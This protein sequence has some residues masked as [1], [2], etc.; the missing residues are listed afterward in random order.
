MPS[1]INSSHLTD[2]ACAELRPWLPE[3]ADGQPLP[4]EAAHLAAHLPACPACQAELA[5]LRQLF[6]DLDALPPELPPLTMRDDFQ[7]M[8]EAEKAKLAA[9]SPADLTAA[10]GGQPLASPPVP[11]VHSERQSATAEHRQ[12][13]RIAASVALVAVGAV[14]GLLLRGSQPATQLAQ[15]EQ[16]QQPTLSARLAAARQPRR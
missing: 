16:P 13:L 11:A 12:W 1:A 2:P 15:N 5:E 10:R 4:P 7:A 8:L 6:N 3:L 9:A 14:L